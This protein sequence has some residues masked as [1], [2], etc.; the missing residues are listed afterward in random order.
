MK[1]CIALVLILLLLPI[2]SLAVG[3][4][5]IIPDSDTR[6]LSEAE[7]WEWDY[8]SLGYILNEIFARHGY[9]FNPGGKYDNYFS[10][11]PWYTP[12]A[13]PDNSVACYPQLTKT[14]WANEKLVKD[15][16]GVMRDT[17]NYNLGGL[18]YL[19][20]ISFDNFDVLSGFAFIDLK[21]GQKLA[22]YSAP[23]QN[24]Y[25]GANGKAL[26]STN[27][28]VYAAGWNQGWLLVMYATNNGAV[29]VGYVNGHDIKGTVDAP[30][31]SFDNKTIT[32]TSDA[33]L[34]DDPA[35][36]NSAIIRLTAGR[37]VTYLT[38]FYNH[39]TWAYIETTIGGLTV[40]GFIPSSAMD[41]N[42]VDDEDIGK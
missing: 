32:L 14:E 26:V 25:R 36:D 30:Y 10:Q 38:T 2:A 1:K 39:K 41:W 6:P 13:N 20:F 18:N 28:T 4:Q 12:N 24:A 33:S 23:S 29:R 34:T 27:G 31:L 8:E 40:R 5:Y 7:L 15:V 21:A 22:V 9:N 11:L 37:Q 42:S 17:D 16:R 35:T 19:D 3:R